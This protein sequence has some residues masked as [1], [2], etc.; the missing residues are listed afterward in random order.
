MDN[1]N[2]PLQLSDIDV[3]FGPVDGIRVLL[4]KWEEIP[5]EFIDGTKHNN[6]WIKAVD[7]WF[8]NGIKLINVVMKEGVEKP[9]AI[10]HISSIVRSWEPQHEHKV[11]GV[12]YLMSKWFEKFEYEIA[13]K[14][15]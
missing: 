10:T 8:F 7:D 3:E 12:A 15:V 13:K 6:K 1:W 2:K 5:K 11:A 14:K 4:P 9:H